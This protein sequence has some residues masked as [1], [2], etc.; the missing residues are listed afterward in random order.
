[1][2]KKIFFAYFLLYGNYLFPFTDNSLENTKMCKMLN[3]MVISSGKTKN[4]LSGVVSVGMAGAAYWLLCD[5]NKHNNPRFIIISRLLLVKKLRQEDIENKKF[6]CLNDAE[7]KK[8]L[9]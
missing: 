8:L 1:M 5:L 2:V 3:D 7:L 6:D 9:I 4:A